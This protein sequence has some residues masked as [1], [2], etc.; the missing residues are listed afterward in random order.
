[1]KKAYNLG[2]RFR[3]QSDQDQHS[4]YKMVIPSTSLIKI[5]CLRKSEVS[6][7]RIYFC[8]VMEKLEEHII[9]CL[10]CSF[11]KDVIYL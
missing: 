11:T 5:I 3:L 6:V 2:A 10:L 4:I 7:E 1:M 8:N 9:H